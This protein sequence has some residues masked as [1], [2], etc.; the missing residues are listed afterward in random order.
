[1]LTWVFGWSG[2]KE[3]VSTSYVDAKAKAAEQKAGRAEKK[4][5][6][7]AAKAAARNA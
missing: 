7:K 3:L 2:G 4:E 1:M 6:K 5:A